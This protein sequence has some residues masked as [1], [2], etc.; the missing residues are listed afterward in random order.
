MGQ[1]VLDK[2]PLVTLGRYIMLF[3][4]RLLSFLRL[5]HLSGREV[6]K[7]RMRG[8]TT[9]EVDWVSEEVP[10]LVGPP[11]NLVLYM[12]LKIFE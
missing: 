8:V 10:D 11:L 2:V 6:S 5:L 3:I 7:V 12:Y 9:L 4:V 1:P